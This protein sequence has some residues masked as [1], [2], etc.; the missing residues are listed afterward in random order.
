[1]IIIKTPKEIELM[2]EGGEILAKVLREVS[3]RVKPGVSTQE[4]DS[5]AEE[6]IIKSK[7]KPSFKGYKGY[8]A[9]LCASVNNEVVH[10]IPSSEKI[11]KSGDI[12][13]LDLGLEYKGCFTDMTITVPVGKVSKI[14]HKLIKVT[15]NSLTQGIRKIE[16]GNFISDISRAIQDYVERQGFSVV[17]DLVG[18]G[19]GREVHEDPPVPNF[20]DPNLESVKLREGMVLALEPMINMGSYEV[21]VLN[22]G[23]TVV[24]RDGFLSAH[25]EH[26][27]AVTKEGYEILTII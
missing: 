13:G 24:T 16:P 11:L 8:P 4:L 6:L 17:R 7:G 18:H 20:F 25:F 2:R 10:G 14:A 15:K 22:D 27:V 21:E 26:T 1:M 23:W 3:L 19:V 12:V 5:L 9:A